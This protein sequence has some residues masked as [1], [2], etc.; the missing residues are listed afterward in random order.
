MLSFGNS[1][2]INNLYNIKV[3]FCT[4]KLN[5]TGSRGLKREI[6]RS[7]PK[8]NLMDIASLSSDADDYHVEYWTESSSPEDDTFNKTS[9][10][11][12]KI[13]G[14]FVPLQNDNFTF[15]IR[16]DDKSELYLSPTGEPAGKV[17]KLFLLLFH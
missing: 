15:Y 11:S 6:W 17:Q 7:T 10:Y 12:S 13:S 2:K 8:S 4:K 14:F 16:S 3:F 1:L 5:V 9:G